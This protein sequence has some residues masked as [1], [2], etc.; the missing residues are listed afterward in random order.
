MQWWVLTRITSETV[1]VPG[2]TSLVRVRV[3]VGNRVRVTEPWLLSGF[4][5][6]LWLGSGSVLG[7][8]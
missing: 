7:S 5:F 2:R 3:R 8:G 1:R 6:G 4:G